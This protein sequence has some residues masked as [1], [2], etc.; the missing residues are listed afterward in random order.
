MAGAVQFLEAQLVRAV[1][2]AVVLLLRRAVVALLAL[3]L[4]PVLVLE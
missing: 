3:V 1:P 2:E 4:M